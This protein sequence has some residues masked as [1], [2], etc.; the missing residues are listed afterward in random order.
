MAGTDTSNT[1]DTSYDTDDS[2]GMESQERL[3]CQMAG[4]RAKLNRMTSRDDAPAMNLENFK[5]KLREMRARKKMDLAQAAADYA[6][7]P[8]LLEFKDSY[9]RRENTRKRR[10]LLSSASADIAG[11]ETNQP[12]GDVHGVEP[13]GNAQPVHSDPPAAPKEPT[14]D[15]D[16]MPQAFQSPTT[17]TTSPQSGLRSGTVRPSP[18]T[19]QQQMEDRKKDKKDKARKLREIFDRAKGSKK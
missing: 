17:A 4:M 15:P 12:T 6:D 1:T 14:P 7:E 2:L 10:Q 16:P 18:P 13:L 9:I 8:D 5:Q 3:L 19:L 11:V